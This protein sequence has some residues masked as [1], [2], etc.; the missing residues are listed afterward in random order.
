MVFTSTHAWGIALQA[1]AA[2]CV[3]EGWLTREV[4][5]IWTIIPMQAAAV[6]VGGPCFFTLSEAH[7]PFKA[8]ALAECLAVAVASSGFSF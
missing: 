6:Q 3:Q 8:T 5:M 2:V 7:F 4:A 1:Q